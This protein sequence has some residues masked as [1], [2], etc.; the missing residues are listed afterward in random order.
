[1]MRWTPCREQTPTREPARR[2]T[3]WWREYS[4][5]VPDWFE[6]YI[7]L[8]DGAA[9]I[10]TYELEF[11]PGLLQ[12]ADY[13]RALVRSDFPDAPDEIVERRVALR[14]RRQRLL[15][16]PTRFWA[17]VDEAAL[18]RPLCGARVMRRQIEHLIE[19]A[20]FPNVTIQVLPFDRESA[21]SGFSIL[22]FAQPGLPDVVY[23][24]EL[25]SALYVER[26]DKVDHCL[27]TMERLCVDA[28][29][30]LRTPEVL[31][32]IRREV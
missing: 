13:V 11:V 5:V 7:G 30:P 2:S 22:R 20:E 10:R 18:R 15:T 31:A 23:V 9:R 24:E 6:T 27:A 32:R 28:E 26:R 17:V 21:A 25:T 14:M 29:P 16:G 19:M 4:D 3:A 8:E 1:M 12:T